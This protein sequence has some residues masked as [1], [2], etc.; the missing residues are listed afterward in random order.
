MK[1]GV[2][3]ESTDKCAHGEKEKTM[4]FA[5]LTNI[6]HTFSNRRW[7]G[8]NTPKI[9]I[10][11]HKSNDFQLIYFM[12]VIVISSYYILVELCYITFLLIIQI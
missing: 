1:V 6:L 12:C 3:L 4:K 5:L 2:F 8:L 7:V 11:T 9:K 10:S